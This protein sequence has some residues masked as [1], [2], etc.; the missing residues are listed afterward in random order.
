[1]GL[2]F[3]DLRGTGVSLIITPQLNAGVLLQCNDTFFSLTKQQKLYANNLK[4]LI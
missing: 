3:S 4:N 1:M 2:N